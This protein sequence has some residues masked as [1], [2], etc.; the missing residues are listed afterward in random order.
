MKKNTLPL[1]PELVEQCAKET[2]QFFKTGEGKKGTNCLQL[3]KQAVIQRDDQAWEA[4]YRQ[5]APLVKSWVLRHPAFQRT[6][7][8]ADYFVN[9]A[10]ARLW[11]AL[12]PEK[13][14]SF[15]DIRSV[16]SYLQTCTH[17]AIL[18]KVRNRQAEWVDID[19]RV[20]L[21][22]LHTEESQFGKKVHQSLYCQEVLAAVNERL[23]T[24][25]ER[26][27]LYEAYVLGL[28]P[29][30]IFERH[31]DMFREVHDIYR[32]KENVLTRLRRDKELQKLFA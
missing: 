24:P 4:F 19:A 12:T 28:K 13:C 14:D 8:E 20:I 3:F 23:K 11:G 17:S 5:Y 32:I 21:N 2:N 27:V 26:M 18:D 31:P 15:N 1:I 25:Q 22:Q 30:E 6:G 10:F 7:E 16:L 29:G 9:A